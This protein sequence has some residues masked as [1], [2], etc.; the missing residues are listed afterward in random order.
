[1][2]CTRHHVYLSC[3]STVC[4]SSDEQESSSVK[5]TVQQSYEREL[6]TSLFFHNRDFIMMC[7]YRNHTVPIIYSLHLLHWYAFCQC[8]RQLF[9]CVRLL[10]TG[11]NKSWQLLPLLSLWLVSIHSSAGS[12]LMCRM[13][14]TGEMFIIIRRVTP[15]FK[16]SQCYNNMHNV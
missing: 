14:S 15:V 2:Y 13:C 1:M 4:Y 8:T 12:M 3:P 6:R 10:P 16:I 11:Y 5:E 7:T 9:L